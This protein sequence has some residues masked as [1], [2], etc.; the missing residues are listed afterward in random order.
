MSCS[1]A[2]QQLMLGKHTK[3]RRKTGN[4]T[5]EWVENSVQALSIWRLEMFVMIDALGNSR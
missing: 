2:L 3:V 4:A 1:Q 5:Q